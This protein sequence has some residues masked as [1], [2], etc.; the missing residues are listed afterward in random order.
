[1]NTARKLPGRVPPSGEIMLGE[2]N[3]EMKATN[4][5][6]VHA[7]MKVTEINQINFWKVHCKSILIVIR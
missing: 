6:G 7:V 2:M 5:Y 3:E 4:A 1:M